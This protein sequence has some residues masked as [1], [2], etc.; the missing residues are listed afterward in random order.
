MK[1]YAKAES[2]VARG[3]ELGLRITLDNDKESVGRKIRESELWK[4]PYVLVVGEKEAGSGEVI[5]RV[6]SDMQVGEPK[7]MKIEN[8]LQTVA[9]EAKSRVSKSSL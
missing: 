3:K 6:R 7:S 8:F 1:S 9:N 5:P 4:V 2:I